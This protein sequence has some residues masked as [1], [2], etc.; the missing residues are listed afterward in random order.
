RPW[1]VWF[2]S[3]HAS[4]VRG[5]VVVMATPD[6]SAHPELAKWA[7]C[8]AQPPTPLTACW[9]RPTDVP[10]CAPCRED[11]HRAWVGAGIVMETVRVTDPEQVD[12]LDRARTRGVS[13][14]TTSGL[15][16]LVRDR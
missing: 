16:T 10:E 15:P 2:C 5:A 4:P 1:P 3:R 6:H 9:K 11:L 12:R 14:C 8:G 13:I 7:M